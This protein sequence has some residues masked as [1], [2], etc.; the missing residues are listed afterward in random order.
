MKFLQGKYA[1][2]LLLLFIISGCSGGGTS[3]PV[4]GGSNPRPVNENNIGDREANALGQ[5]LNG[6]SILF[7][8]R[9][10]EAVY[11]TYFFEQVHF[12]DSDDYLLFGYSERNTVLDNIQRNRWQD[13]GRWELRREQGQ[14]GV[15]LQPDSAQGYFVPLR[16]DNN[17]RLVNPYVSV[18]QE[19]HATC[20]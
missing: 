17:G 6:N 2:F 20:S 4:S 15:Y 18:S 10:G 16:F 8:W 7:S 9:E 13:E 14:L 5:A 1:I 3:E 11:G 19:G 12:C